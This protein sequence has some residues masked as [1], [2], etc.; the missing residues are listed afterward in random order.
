MCMKPPYEI[1]RIILKSYGEIT[2]SLGQAKSLLLMKPEAK[3]RRQNRI[4][5]IHSSLAIEGNTLD[6]DQVSAILENARVVGPEKD[7][8]EVQNA[9]E[10]YELLTSFDVY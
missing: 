10:V 4:K 8:R 7:I 5:T 3:L 1:T 2:E 9:A 6:I